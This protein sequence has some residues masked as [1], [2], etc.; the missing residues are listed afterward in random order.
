MSTVFPTQPLLKKKTKK[1]NMIIKAFRNKNLA[2]T[3]T[4]I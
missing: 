1:K 4:H 3:A 2:I